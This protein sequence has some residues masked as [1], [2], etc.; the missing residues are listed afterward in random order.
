MNSVESLR[1]RDTPVALIAGERDTLI[2]TRR[3]DALRRKVPNLV[4][5]R[6]I[7]GAGHNDIYE[8]PEFRQAMREA[9][10]VLQR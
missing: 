7:A 8:R 10:T 1:G 9:I 6:T 3:T 2:P 4:Y 5:D